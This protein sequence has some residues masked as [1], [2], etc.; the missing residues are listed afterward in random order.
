M[1]RG[2]G[3]GDTDNV[4]IIVWG[5][6]VWTQDPDALPL[7]NSSTWT[8]PTVPRHNCYHSPPPPVP[9]MNAVTAPAAIC[10]SCCTVSLIPPH[11]YRKPV[12]PHLYRHECGCDPQPDVL[13]DA[14]AR[15]VQDQHAPTLRPQHNAAN[16]IRLHREVGEGGRI[17]DQHAPALCPRHDA[18]CDIRLSAQGGGGGGGG[19]G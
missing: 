12:P 7:L 5:G 13:D 6:E 17:E 4:R 11:L 19:G 8:V 14:G 1:G 18:A 16:G 2:E 3:R 10:S 15:G 9:P